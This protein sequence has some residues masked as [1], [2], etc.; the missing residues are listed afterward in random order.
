MTRKVTT[1]IIFETN[2]TIF[3]CFRST[4]VSVIPVLNGARVLEWNRSSR[5]RDACT[6]TEGKNRRRP[7]LVKER[8]EGLE[9]PMMSPNLISSNNKAY[10]RDDLVRGGAVEWRVEQ[11]ERSR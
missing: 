5:T 9:L 7:R 8:T 3:Y 4:K 10:E 2:K 1:Q 11:L 6:E